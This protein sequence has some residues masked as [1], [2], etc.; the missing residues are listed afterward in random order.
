[1]SEP[2]Y[3]T[4][5]D[6]GGIGALLNGAAE[7]FRT[8]AVTYRT[9]RHE[10]RLREAFRANADKQQ[11]R[12]FTFGAVGSGG[13]GPAET[14]ETVRIWREGQRVRQE[15]HGG[16]RDGSYGVVDGPRWWSWSEQMGA[17]SNRDNT[18][19]GGGGIDGGFEVML[20]PAALVGVL[21]LRVVGNSRIAGRS[22]VTVTAA[23][24]PEGLSDMRASSFPRVFRALHALG[25]GADSYQLEV[26]RQRGVLLAT[27]AIRNELP[28]YT[29][30]TLAIGFDEPIPA[31]TFVF[32]PPDGEQIRS[33]Q[34]VFPIPRF[35]PLAEALQQATFTVLVPD[36]LPAGWRQV[37]R[38]ASNEASSRFAASVALFYRSGHQSVSIRQIPAADAPRHYGMI[39][40]D[41][42]W[43]EVLRDATPIKITPAGQRPCAQAYL[44]RDGTF[45]YLKSEGLTTDELATIAASLRP[46]SETD[47]A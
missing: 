13:P 37:P 17:M 8:V 29:I 5:D 16:L 42:S 4:A 27:T 36:R 43:D 6:E 41:E 25:S 18:S 28:F 44:T 39:L 45:A 9:W 33:P 34:E 12:G 21:D 32:T 40:D 7:S 35:V 14:G 10:Q 20:D 23:P 15:H 11:R 1:M 47:S 24:Q 26:D 19:V 46:A 3:P 22:T 38:C 31:D 30:T 2:S